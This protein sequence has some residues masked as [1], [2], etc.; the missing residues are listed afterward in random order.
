MVLFDPGNDG[1]R[2]HGDPRFSPGSIAID[3]EPGWPGPA[4]L[5]VPIAPGPATRPSLGVPAPCAPPSGALVRTRD[6]GS[7][8]AGAGGLSMTRQVKFSPRAPPSSGGAQPAPAPLPPGSQA[9]TA[10]PHA[11]QVRSPI[12]PDPQ[13]LGCSTSRSVA[14]AAVQEEAAGA[15]TQS[16]LTREQAPWEAT[17]WEPTTGEGQ[18]IRRLRPYPPTRPGPMSP[19]PCRGEGPS[20]DSGPLRSMRQALCWRRYP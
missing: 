17:L 7:N 1:W 13:S 18:E 10:A 9:R 19:G 5:A 3:G 16:G 4:L 8:V 14:V 2:S 20:L 15:P 6:A 12:P 11:P